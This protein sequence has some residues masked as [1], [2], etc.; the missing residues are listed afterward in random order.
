MCTLPLVVMGYLSRA[1]KFT[2][3]HA[4]GAGSLKTSQGSIGRVIL[5]V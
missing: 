5:F 1:S 4:C 2:T 3:L